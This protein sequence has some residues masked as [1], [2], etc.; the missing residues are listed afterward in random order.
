MGSSC[1]RSVTG[2]AGEILGEKVRGMRAAIMET[3]SLVLTHCRST[4]RNA[5]SIHKQGRKQISQE[6]YRRNS[7]KYLQSR[8]N[9]KEKFQNKANVISKSHQSLCPRHG[10]KSCRHSPC[11]PMLVLGTGQP[12][13]VTPGL[14]TLFLWGKHVQGDVSFH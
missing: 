5:K 1:S 6:T 7:K 13:E 3:E 10:L 4:I 9:M 8:R 14:S 12:M 11:P 2:R